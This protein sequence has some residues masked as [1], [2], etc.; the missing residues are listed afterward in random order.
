VWSSIAPVTLHTVDIWVTCFVEF[1]SFHLVLLEV[2]VADWYHCHC[3][4]CACVPAHWMRLWMLLA[5]LCF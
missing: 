5:V 1:F 4:L 2:T 3:L